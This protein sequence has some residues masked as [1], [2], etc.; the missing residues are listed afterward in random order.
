MFYVRKATAIKKNNMLVR[1]ATPADLYRYKKNK[2]M[3]DSSGESDLNN[4]CNCGCNHNFKLEDFFEN[5]YVFINCE[6]SS[7]DI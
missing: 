7:S 6:L 2:G 5:E 3:F 1:M 4:D